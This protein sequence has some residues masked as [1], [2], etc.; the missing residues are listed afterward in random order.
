MTRTFLTPLLLLAVAVGLFFGYI[1]PAYQKVKTLRAEEARF[2]EALNQSR[3]LQKVRDTLLSR[4]NTFSQTDLER[5]R[6]LLP[7]NVDNVRLILDIDSI[8]SKYNMR[9]RNVTVS[10]ASSESAALNAGQDAIDSVVLSFSVIAEYDD[11]IRFLED[12]ESSL[13]IVDLVGLTFETAGGN[14][15]NFNVSIKTYWLK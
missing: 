5:L 9:T 4:F 1:D 14:A 13:R 8:A 6:K 7:D 11:F 2:N 3:E 15:Y 10:G 12:L